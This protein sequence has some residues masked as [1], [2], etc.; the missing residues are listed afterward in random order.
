MFLSE[1]VATSVSVAATRSRKAKTGLLA[2]LLTSTDSTHLPTVAAWLT[3]DIPQGRLGI[4]WRGVSEVSA[5]PAPE[6]TLTVN[7]VDDAF[8]K[9]LATTG[10]GSVAARKEL[11]AQLLGAAT[12]A[13]QRFL[14]QLLVGELRQG[15]LAGVMVDA[16][17]AA[18]GHPAAAVRRAYMLTGS[19]PETAE[20]ATAGRATLDA[21]GLQVGRPVSPMLAGAADT[22]AQAWEALGPEVIVDAKLDGAR[23]QVHRVNDHVTVFT[24][25]LRNVSDKV[26]D[27]VEAIRALPCD[28]A[29]FDGETLMLDDDGRARPFQDTMSRFGSGPGESPDDTRVLR[30][31]LFDCLHLDGRDLIDEPLAERLAALDGVAAHLRIPYMLPS[32]EADAVDFNRATLADGHEGVMVKSLAASYAAGRRG[33]MWLKVKPVHTLDLVVLAAEWGSGRRRGFLSNIHLGVRDPH[34]GPPIMVGKT[35]KGLTDALLQWQTTEFPKHEV[36]RDDYT[37]YLRPDIVVEIEL[38]GVQRSSRYPGGVSLRFARVNRYRPDKTAAEVDTI[39][40]VRELL[41]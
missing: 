19:L 21:V 9:L 26:P 28:R 34:G 1:V 2:E 33:K 31:Y 38:D 25:S 4:G 14:G 13:E 32:T 29:I 8:G 24:R 22:V 7:A 40:A 30:P 15:A 10:P 20:L 12:E 27:L 35:F 5:D 39:D 3:G 6:P 17:A 16:I 41:R 37:V 11:L 18:T 23:I 36:R